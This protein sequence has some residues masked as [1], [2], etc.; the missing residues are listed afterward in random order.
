[1][2][3]RSGTGRAILSAEDAMDGSGTF[4][5]TG[6]TGFIGSR[7]VAE[8]VHRGHTVRALTRAMTDPRIPDLEGSTPV[9]GDILDPA[10]LARAVDGCSRIFH[11]AAYAKNWARDPRTFA[12]HNVRGTRNVL[13]A[14]REVGVEKLVLTSSIATLGP[15]P[16]GVVGDET[17][18]RATSLFFTTYEETKTLAER[19]ALRFAADG[20]PV[21][22]VNPT[23]VYGPG[24]LGEANSVTVLID[25]YDRGRFPF[26]LAGGRNVGNYALVDD[27][28]RG[29]ILAMEKGRTGERYILGGENA[30]LADLMRTVDEV[31]GKTHFTLPLPANLAMVYGYLEEAKARW[32]GAYPRVTPGWVETFLHDW[33]YS[34]AKAEHELGYAFTPLVAGVRL[35]HE[36]LVRRRTGNGSPP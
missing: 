2:T 17:M 13:A 12:E 8:L 36:W 27:V 16:P 5:V 3:W 28:V 9:I 19:D 20:L 25:L 35:T 24:K 21:L 32:L 4:L 29:H 11:L 31:S 33:A 1:M 6:A 34:C 23:R 26:L 7:L 22:V 18:P 10:A 14:A 15:T 30:S